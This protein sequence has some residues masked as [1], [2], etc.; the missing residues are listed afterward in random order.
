MRRRPRHDVDLLEREFFRVLA[1]LGDDVRP[2]PAE[3]GNL[4]VDVEH[5][6]FQEGRAIK[7]NDRPWISR[8]VQLKI[9]LAPDNSSGRER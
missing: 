4:P 7:R 5:L 9:K 6:R 3:R 8:F 2:D 1:F